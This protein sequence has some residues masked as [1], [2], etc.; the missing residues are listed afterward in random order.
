[1]LK[2]EK[3]LVTGSSGFIGYHLCEFLLKNNYI[4]AGI[5]GLTNYYDINL[6]KNRGKI[7]L[8]NK[9]FK[10]FY[11][12]LEDKE[13]LKK[14]FNIFKPSKIIHLAAQAGVRYALENP[15]SYVDSNLL[16]TF[17]I[18]EAAKEFNVSHLLSASSSSVYGITD[19]LPFKE[20]QRSDYPISFY[21]ASKK[22]NELMCH[23]YSY[24]HSIPTTMLRLFTAYGP[25]GRP[26]MALFKF[27]DAIQNNKVIDVYNNGLMKRDFTY[28]T[29]VIKS[30]YLLMDVIPEIP[31]KRVRKIKN[32][33]IS[34]VAPWRVVNIGSSNSIKLLDF[35][36]II[37]EQL[38]KVAK[39]NFLPIQ[40]GDVL[41]T[42]ACNELLNELIAYKPE[43]D[44]E[45]GVKNFVK[46]YLSYH[47]QNY[48]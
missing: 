19:N 22:A 36:S 25:Y 24:L 14:T 38:E 33:S 31:K 30:I 34:E 43:T 46:W 15:Q 39:K 21:A 3:I 45:F 7:L 35:I 16:G 48:D 11:G 40:P 1:M 12:K 6:K 10:F 41:E 32:D 17:N 47:N 28:I 18:L 8:Q 20:K 2:D 23:S 27:T 37:E 5:D 44:I 29:D 26:D 42:Y 13:F 9:N 4:V